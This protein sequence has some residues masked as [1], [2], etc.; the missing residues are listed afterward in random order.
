[1]VAGGDG[2]LHAVVAALHKRHELAGATLGL[3]PLG[4][5]NDFA[6]GNDIPLEIEDA[7]RLVLAGEARP[8]DLIVDETGSI[9][10]NNVHVG[11][12]A[13]ASRKGAQVEGPPRLGRGRQGQ[14]RQA[15]LPHRR[16][17]RPR[18]TRRAGACA[19]RSTARSSTTST[20]RC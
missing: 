1:M 14:P 16:P 10:V 4:T 17:A 3:L 13:Q 9:V 12:G 11:V 15:R 5:G 7:A 8:V 2:S 20:D 19:S 6:R 18:S